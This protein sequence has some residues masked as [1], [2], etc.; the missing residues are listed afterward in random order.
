[1]SRSR[2]AEPA[3]LGID[4][5]GTKIEGVLLA[6][7]ADSGA[8]PSAAVQCRRRIAT[9][10]ERGYDHI[11]ARTAALMRDLAGDVWGG[12]TIGVGHPGH[13]A[14][15]DRTL[16]NSNTTCL[17]GRPLAADLERAV[18]RSIAF[19]NDA[20]CF[21][22]AEAL[23]GAGRGARVVFGVIA[24]TGVGGGI[25]IDGAVW[26]GRHHIAGEWGHT[27]LAENGPACYC[28]RHG[29]VETYLA[30]PGLEREI[31]HRLG[32]ALTAEAFNAQLANPEFRERLAVRM[33]LRDY[34]D[35]FGAALARVVNILDPDV[36][37]LGGGMS[38][39]ALLYDRL[40]QAVAPHVFNDRFDTPIRAALL[41]DSAGVFG[42]A[43]LGAAGD[44][45]D[46]RPHAPRAFHR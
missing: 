1:M 43:W 2:S 11:V 18:G 27:P 28:G 35:R 30:G 15:A 36:I 46:G 24:G 8:D 6:P 22:L 38:K 31:T 25:V 3:R 7:G 12:V 14:P 17:N 34:L 10:A 4:L 40:P 13:F 32:V 9:E 5:G 21:A 45:E 41:G 39:L 29:C 26:S 37:V 19:G 44:A 23:W 42:A 20:N 16:R 33:L